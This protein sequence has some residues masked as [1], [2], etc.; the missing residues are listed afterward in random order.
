VKS[1][2]GHL[3]GAAGAAGLLKT[4]LALR[5]KV[6]PP[7]V[8]CEHPS[9][10]ID[11]AHSPLY[12]NGELK[13]WTAVADGVRRA[14]V[15]AFGFGGTN[16]HAVLEEYIPHR[17]TGNGKRVA[18]REAPPRFR[19]RP[20]RGRRSRPQP[21][22]QKLRLRGALLIG[23]PTAPTGAASAAVQRAAARAT[24]R[25][26]AA[27]SE[28]DLHAPRA[29]GDRLRRRRRPGGQIGQGAQGAGGRSASRLE[30][31]PLARR[32]PRSRSRA[33]GGLPLYRPR[34]AIREHAEH[35]PRGR[36]HRRRLLPKRTA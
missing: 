17:L 27:P 16:F 4:A 30:S 29:P 31:A 35:A 14:G 5:D 13:P 9:P 18:M 6:L 7:S 15:S 26:R 22:P 8:H 24:R 28:S 20:R 32:L 21:A 25:R 34:L 12:V 1:N 2:I 11:F 19:G 36:T 10:D 33:Q 3:K 23:A